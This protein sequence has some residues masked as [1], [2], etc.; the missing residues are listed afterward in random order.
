M[1]TFSIAAVVVVNTLILVRYGTLIVRRRIQPSLAM[2]LFFTIA[3]AGSLLTYLSSG[4]F[5]LLDNIVNSSDIVLVVVVTILIA[6]FG[7]RATMFSA[8]DTVCLA[9]VLVIVG[10]WIATNNHTISHILIQ[11][12]MVI[13]Y[14]PVVKRLWISSRNT[15]SYLAWIG[16]LLAPT[17]SLLS[18][19]GMLAT[20]YSVRAMVCTVLLLALMVRTDLRA[21]RRS[22]AA[23]EALDRRP[24]SKAA[25]S[26]RPHPSSQD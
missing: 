11:T 12:I 19:E 8:F 9:A 24:Q 6:V 22:D 20:I 18:S 7:D 3:A 16:L 25:H 26:S 15:E 5:S 23:I 17:L 14:V 1:R 2:W 4:D 13:A 21:R 10:F